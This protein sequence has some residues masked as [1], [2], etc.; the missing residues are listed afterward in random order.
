M[1]STLFGASDANNSISIA[2]F[3]VPNT[4]TG[5]A[6]AGFAGAD[7]PVTPADTSPPN[8]SIIARNTTRRIAASPAASRSPCYSVGPWRPVHGRN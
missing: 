2:P 7:C 6:D 4:S 1:C 3:A 8:A 5:L